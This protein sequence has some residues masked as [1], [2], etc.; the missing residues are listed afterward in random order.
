MKYGYFDIPSDISK[1]RSYHELVQEHRQLAAI[2]DQSGFDVFWFG[3]HHF[4]I[5]GR[6]LSPNPILLAADIAARTERVRMGLAAAIITFWHPLRLAEDIA[7]LDHLTGGRLEVGV[8]R[9]NYGLEALNLNPE[10]DPNNPQENFNVFDETLQILKQALTEE[11]FSHK[12]R[13]YQFPEPGFNADRAHTVDDPAF[14]DADT[15]ELIKLETLPRPYQQPLPPLWIVVNSEL[16]IQHAAQNDC[17]IMMWRASVPTLKRRLAVYRET[18]EK[19]H[20]RALAKGAKT[21][22]LRDTFVADSFDEARRV[23][24]DAVMGA[25]NFSNWRGPYIFLD[26][27]EKLDPAYYAE[28]EKA[29]TFDFVNERALLFGSPDDVVEK[30]LR[31]H[32]ETNIEQVVFR[33]GWPGLAHEHTARSVERLR[34]DVIPRVNAE[35]AARRAM[36]QAPAAE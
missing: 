23:A 21:A 18:Y 9:G 15:N 14:V 19:T 24:G 2:C 1:T 11:R 20:G 17:G 31:L 16:S 32:E 5:W 36:S 30:L 28:L 6:E 8:G 34:D 3:E 35:L 4:S 7:T 25:F 22:I 13:Y 26:P 10:A 33:C 27:D 12:G 29:L